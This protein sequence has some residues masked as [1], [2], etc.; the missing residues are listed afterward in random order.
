MNTTLRSPKET[1]HPTV[2]GSAQDGGVVLNGRAKGGELGLG[3][4]SNPGHLHAYSLYAG[5]HTL[6]T[7]GQ[8]T[9]LGHYIP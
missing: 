1:G 9:W 5:M 7:V 3:P 8:A 2:C 6:S 4:G